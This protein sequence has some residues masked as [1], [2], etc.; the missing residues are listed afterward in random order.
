MGNVI[1][2]GENESEE[3]D[4]KLTNYDSSGYYYGKFKLLNIY[5]RDLYFKSYILYSFHFSL[6]IAHVRLLETNENVDFDKVS[7]HV[8]L[9]ERIR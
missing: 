4:R 6:I 2:F 3:F 9:L 7:A 5:I 1:I 8:R